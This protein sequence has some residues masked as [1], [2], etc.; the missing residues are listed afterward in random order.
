MADH[1]SAPVPAA[2][3][4]R[5]FNSMVL[6]LRSQT[7]IMMHI[8]EYAQSKEVADWL[9]SLLNLVASERMKSQQ[10]QTIEK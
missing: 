4:Q 9:V 3:S 7:C 6:A 1:G 2:R 10:R 8:A 5:L